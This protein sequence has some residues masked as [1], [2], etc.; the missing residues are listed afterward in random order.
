MKTGDMAS[1]EI[2]DAKLD[3]LALVVGADGVMLS[4]RSNGGSPKGGITW[5]K[6]K[7][8]ILARMGPRLDR[9]GRQ[10]THI[11]A[12][13]LVATLG[14]TDDLVVRLRVEGLRQPV[15]RAMHF[16]WVNGRARVMWRASAELFTD[17]VIRLIDFYHAAAHLWK[18]AEALIAYRDSALIR[19]AT[20]RHSSDH[21][22]AGDII[23]DLA[24][25]VA[26]TVCGPKRSAVLSQVHHYFDRHSEHLRFPDDSGA[27]LRRSSGLVAST[28]KRVFQKRFKGVGMR[29]SE[30]GSNLPF[31]LLPAWVNDRFDSLV[32]L[33]SAPSPNS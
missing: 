4:F 8:G 33:R 16:A 20:A 13:W 29:W 7:I 22:G 26:Q 23:A 12:R 24:R 3:E 28:C 10:V 31:L 11:A 32:Q 14:S 1:Q 9:H 19:I 30:D 27:G 15:G 6:A 21:G 25:A 17:E 18:S 2:I 5:R